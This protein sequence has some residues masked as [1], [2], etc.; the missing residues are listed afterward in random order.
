[1]RSKIWRRL[2][3]YGLGW[4]LSYPIVLQM[5]LISAIAAPIK[6]KLPPP[7]P[8]GITGHRS[9]AASRDP[10]CP[11]VARPLTA[12]VPEYRDSQGDRVWGLTGMTRPTLWFYVPYAP[13]SIVDMSFTLQDESNPADTKIIY[14]NLKI[15]PAQTPGMLQIV[16]PKSI[17]PLATNKSYHWFLI[18]NTS[19]TIGQRPFFVDGWV[20]RM[21]MQP[22][23][24][25]AIKRATP[26]RRVALYAENGL[27][28][29]AIATLATLRSAKPQDPSLLQAWQELL[30]AI[31]LKYL[32]DRS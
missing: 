7:P 6:L 25:Q 30:D 23:L 3:L 32:A 9:A 27:W 29:D 10:A 18:L 4:L 26:I 24:S 21:D 14:Q 8:R 19:C 11:V 1:M 31:G 28:Y 17:E 22:D 15:A 16:L 5:S 20:Q 2:S 12:L 13:N